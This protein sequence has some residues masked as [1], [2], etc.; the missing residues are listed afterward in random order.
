MASEKRIAIS[1]VFWSNIQRWLIADA[2]R[3][4]G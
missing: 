4:S 2:I 1:V 3:Q